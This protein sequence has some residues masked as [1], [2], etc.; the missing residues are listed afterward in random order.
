MIVSTPGSSP[1]TPTSRAAS[2]SRPATKRIACSEGLPVRII[3]A[4][5]MWRM[6]PTMALEYPI[7]RPW[8]VAKKGTF[9][10]TYSFAP[11]QTARQA[12]SMS[13]MWQ[14][15]CHPTYTA[16]ADAGSPS[17][18]ASVSMPASRNACPT[19]G[20]PSTRARRMPARAMW[21]AVTLEGVSICSSSTGSPIARSFAA[22]SAGGHALP[23]VS[24]TNGTPRSRSRSSTAM[25]PGS[26]S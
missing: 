3:G 5:V 20:L 7:V 23:L 13:R 14:S 2:P 19:P 8:R 21:C 6:A 22:C 15:G 10:A 25:E 16:S 1:T 17:P 26:T 11:P 18:G 9:D 12:A 4:C 24:T